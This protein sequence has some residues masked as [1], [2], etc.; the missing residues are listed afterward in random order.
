MYN[1]IATKLSASDPVIATEVRNVLDGT[2]ALEP[3]QLAV[4]TDTVDKVQKAIEQR[5]GNDLATQRGN[6]ELIPLV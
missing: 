5:D 1:E 6:L 2:T 3:L 4:F